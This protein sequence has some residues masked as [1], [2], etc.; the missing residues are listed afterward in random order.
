MTRFAAQGLSFG[1][2]RDRQLFSDVSMEPKPGEIVVLLGAN[3]AGKTTLLRILAGQ[4]RPH[5]GVVTL[6][7][8]PIERYGRQS[9]ARRLAFMPQFEHRDCG[10]SVREVVRLGRSPHRGWWLPLTREDERCVDDA[11][12]ALGL[13]QLAEQPITEL[14]GGEWRRMIFAR[15]LAQHASVLLLDE[16]TDGLDLKYQYECL[17]MARNLVRQHQLIAILTLHDLNQAAMYADRIALMGQSRML[18]VGTPEQVLSAEQIRLAYGIGVTITPH[19]VLGTP[20]VVP[21][22]DD[23]LRS[24]ASTAELRGPG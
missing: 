11:M 5:S 14:S 1:Y 17:A 13:G 4:L 2:R 6:D 24:P 8:Q 19:P 15:A 3:G 23:A 22:I 12:A 9:L 21:C 7:D 10:L 18:A 20:M 16:P